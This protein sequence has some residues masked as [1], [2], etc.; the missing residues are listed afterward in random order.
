MKNQKNNQIQKLFGMLNSSLYIA[1]VT[2]FLGGMLTSC[3]GN[4]LDKIT[5][6]FGDDSTE[7]VDDD[8]EDDPEVDVPEP[9][10]AGPATP[11][12]TPEPAAT[13]IES[14]GIDSKDFTLPAGQTKQLKAN[15]QP[16]VN[17][18]EVTWKSSDVRVATVDEKTGV[19][20]AVK[21]GSAN[22]IAQAT[23]SQQ[24]ASVMV[25]VTP[26]PV[27][28]NPNYGTVNLGYGVYTGDLK[29][30]KPHGHGT[31]VYSTYHKVVNSADY[32]AERGDKYEGDFRD[33]RISGGMGYFYHN[34]DVVAINP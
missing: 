21:E 28:G 14:I 6:L 15:V 7:V 22:I 12:A 34:G 4:P 8:D 32:Y 25:T 10:Q 27:T 16:A 17:D 2:L 20:K 18:D 31:I 24:S 30:G 11:V 19:V 3:D 13:L 23:G 26:K 1:L 29:N 9:P 5:S 33:G